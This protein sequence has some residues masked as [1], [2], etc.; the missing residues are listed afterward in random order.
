M[1]LVHSFRP[2]YLAVV[3]LGIHAAL[4]GW[5]ATRHSPSPDE[6]GH[7]GA[8]LHHW[9]TGTFDLYRVNP[10]LVRLL[11]TA[12]VALLGARERDTEV[13][14]HP[15]NRPEFFVGRDFVNDHRARA[16]WYFTLARWACLPLTL[17]G[18]YIC[19]RWGRELYGP[20]AALL[21]LALWCFSPMMLANAQM[22]TPD[23]GAAALG[24]LA[25]YL[26][27][28]WFREPSWPRAYWM[29]VGLGLALLCKTS[30][31]LLLPLWPLSWIVLRSTQRPLL[32]WRA[33]L[34]EG[35]QVACSFLLGLVLINV[36]YL[37]EGSFM[38]LGRYTF[39]S[40]PLTVARDG[41][42][43]NRFTDTWAGALPMP[44]PRNF[45][46]GI[47]VQRRDFERRYWSYLG[48]E[49]RQEGWWYYYL[50]GLGVKW[51]LG[52][53]LLLLLALCTVGLV[54]NRRSTWQDEVLMILPGVSLFA[55]VSSQTGFNH[56]LR[57]VLPALPFAF[58]WIGRVAELSAIRKPLLSSAIM[59]A[60]GWSIGTSL[61]VYPHSMSYFNEL[62]GGPP[63][64]H[65]H[66]VDSNIDWGQDLFYL[67]RWLEEHPEARPLG[68]V[69]FGFIDPRAADVEFSLPARGPTDEA[70]LTGP[71]AATLGPRPGWYAISVT[72]LRGYRFSVPDGKDGMVY[73][74]KEYYT[75]FLRFQPVARAG[76][77]IYIYHL[78]QDACN[79]VRAEMGLPRLK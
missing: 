49:W 18:G 19:Y 32:H 63:N 60:L 65:A 64:G 27:W 67:K 4:V 55:L 43:K 59:I 62:A 31:I 76:Y 17:L 75:Y 30:W 74:D 73:L 11:A 16:F 53:W 22:I 20:K 51:P 23:T 42:L 35:G 56:H 37:F 57:Y 10:P 78:D 40:Q 28:R 12:P 6:V 7:M 68:L 39:I 50:Y 25:C 26:F 45:L 13:N 47:D 46:S 9:H 5:G 3:L 70:D 21:A 58:I 2:G 1:A 8:G 41:Q 79:R 52:N 34:S 69:Y 36:G 44:V 15:F 33:W 29:G 66:L 71:F 48:G 77:S 24:T 54:K 38:Q 61:V 14:T 72:L